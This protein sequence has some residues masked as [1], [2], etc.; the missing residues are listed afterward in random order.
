MLKR[1]LGKLCLLFFVSIGCIATLYHWS[2]RKKKNEFK[3]DFP[4]HILMDENFIDMKFNSYYFAGKTKQTIYLGNYTAPDYVSACNLSSLA[5]T[6]YRLSLPDPRLLK[7]IYFNLV[8]DSPNYFLTNGDKSL[9]YS[10]KFPFLKLQ[11]VTNQF[12][13]S[14]LNFCNLSEG[15]CFLK[16]FDPKE[17]VS[18]ISK[19]SYN[20]YHL[21]KN[22]KILQKQLDGLFDTDGIMQYDLAEH[23]LVF[24][25][26][27]RNQ[28]I[29]TDSNLKILYRGKTIDSNSTVKFSIGLYNHNRTSEI[30]APQQA[31]NRHLVLYQGMIFIQS[32]LVALNEPSNILKERAVVDVYSIQ[33]GHY[34]FSFY[35]PNYQGNPISDFIIDRDRLISISGHFLLSFRLNLPVVH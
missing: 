28:F 23:K 14:F 2:L 20:P 35:I 1:K 31:N 7:T 9:I 22:T 24:L 11:P 6:Q 16:I 33:D 34:K 29:V 5:V 32:G 18:I 4:P 10:C 30:A 15:S 17:T 13:P 26:F 25:Y 8:V 12:L 21:G 3:R 27:Y 19:L